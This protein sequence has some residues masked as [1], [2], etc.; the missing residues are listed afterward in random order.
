MNNRLETIVTGAILAASYLLSGLAVEAKASS[1]NSAVS[2]SSFINLGIRSTSS[3]SP[4]LN[5]LGLSS[6]SPLA[7]NRANQS[8]SSMP[9]PQFSAAVEENSSARSARLPEIAR[10]TVRSPLES[11][12][13][14]SAPA[15]MAQSTRETP[16]SNQE[17]REQLLIEPNTDPIP[18]LDVLDRRPQPIPSSTFITPNAYGADWG[19]F[20]FGLAGTTEDTDDGLDGSASLG[21][22]FGNAVDNVGVEL[23][24]GIISIDGFADDGSVGFKVHKIFPRANNLGVAVGWTNALTWGDADKDEDTI[25]GVATQRFNL[26]PNKDNPMPLTAS[27][28]VG[29]G[30]FRSTGAIAAGDNAPNVFGSVGVRVIPQVSL[31]SSWSG[32]ALGLAAS[33]APFG[34]LPIVFTAGVSDLT[35]NTDAGPQFVGGL[36]YSLG[37]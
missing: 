13:V 12:S 33:A 36:G 22:G 20:Y 4:S 1:V 2:D 37:F 25:Y 15:L 30:A 18:E 9:A 10:K 24:V 6:A 23:N 29:T 35:D 5:T 14:E 7:T 31:V 3:E 26:R 27:L 11:A 16:L 8:A 19:D 17:I 21:M 32:S 28:G 34:R